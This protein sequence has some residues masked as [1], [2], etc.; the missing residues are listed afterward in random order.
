MGSKLVTLAVAVHLNNIE[1]LLLAS[2][3]S[4]IFHSI[5]CA[6]IR[7]VVLLPLLVKPLHLMTACDWCSWDGFLV[8]RGKQRDWGRQSFVRMHAA[9]SGLLQAAAGCDKLLASR[10][11]AICFR[12][13]AF[14]CAW[15]LVHL[16]YWVPQFMS[17]LFWGLWEQAA[18][19]SSSA[20]FRFVT[21]LLICTVQ[22]AYGELQRCVQSYKPLFVMFTNQQKNLLPGASSSLWRQLLAWVRIA[23]KS[24]LFCGTAVIKEVQEILEFLQL[25]CAAVLRWRVDFWGQVYHVSLYDGMWKCWGLGLGPSQSRRHLLLMTAPRGGMLL[26]A[27]AWL[28]HAATCAQAWEE[29]AILA[30]ARPRSA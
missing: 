24:F 18:F 25:I 15:L 13:G 20:S 10:S 14:Q 6:A 11:W 28:P 16:I 3:Y 8:L 17:I 19:W 12:F 7:T 2:K 21:S 22:I 29:A 26:A 5:G 9:P 23:L 1:L 27:G 4:H 30:P